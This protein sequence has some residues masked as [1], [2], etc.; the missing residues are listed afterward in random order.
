MDSVTK[1][2]HGPVSGIPR[3]LAR[4]AAHVLEGYCSCCELMMWRKRYDARGAISRRQR[5]E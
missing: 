3:L 4:Q 1:L 5:L 2:W